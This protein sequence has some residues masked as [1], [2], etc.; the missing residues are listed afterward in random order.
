MMDRETARR[1]KSHLIFDLKNLTT[2]RRILSW[3][4]REWWLLLPQ[5]GR[6]EA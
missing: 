6:E 5:Q 4:R 2:T 3:L 1:P